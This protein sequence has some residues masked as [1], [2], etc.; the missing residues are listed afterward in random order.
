MGSIYINKVE[1]YKDYSNFTT[2]KDFNN[3]IEMFLAVHKEE[4]TNLEFVLFRRLTKYCAKIYGVS[5]ASIR[6]IL[7]AAMELD[8]N[9]ESVSE[10]TFHR[11]KRKAM[12]L[13][14]LES[15]ETKRDNNSQSANLWIFKRYTDNNKADTPTV[16]DREPE[17]TFQQHFNEEKKTPHETSKPIKTNILLTS[18]D[19]L[20]Y[21][22]VPDDVDKSFIDTVRPFFN[23]A[24]DIYML[25]QLT[26]TAYQ[27]SELLIPIYKLQETINKAF[28]T[29]VF[30]FK[31]GKIKK[32]FKG[33][34]YAVLRDNF[35]VIFRQELFQKD[36]LYVDWLG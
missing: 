19:M 32:T 30:F 12:K 5:N 21:T 10:S 3:Q 27:E 7:H 2:L 15:K 23:K 29:A 31:Q 26:M 6:T 36:E 35:N 22:Y 8:L 16:N 33:Y 20:D 4:F 25:W 9:G 14:I 34:F 13:G 18:T 17:V 1:S 24:R 11:M 28:K